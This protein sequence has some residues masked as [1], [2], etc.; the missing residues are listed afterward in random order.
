M[1]QHEFAEDFKLYAQNWVTVPIGIILQNV[2][3]I[4]GTLVCCRICD[5]LCDTQAMI[6]FSVELDL[7]S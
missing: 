7:D 1:K 6:L 3:F 5:K 2:Q 4:N